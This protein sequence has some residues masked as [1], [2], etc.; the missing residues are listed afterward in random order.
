MI[1]VSENTK[2]R[3]FISPQDLICGFR[4][5]QREEVH[6]SWISIHIKVFSNDLVVFYFRSNRMQQ[7]DF[8][9]NNFQETMKQIFKK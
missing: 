7:L 6:L 4:A 9:E 2:W 3:K 5:L 1:K 8:V